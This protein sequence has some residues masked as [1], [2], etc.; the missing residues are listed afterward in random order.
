MDGPRGRRHS[1]DA[2]LGGY[3]RLVD[4]HLGELAGRLVV[5]DR[6]GAVCMHACMGGFVGAKGNE[7]EAAVSGRAWTAAKGGVK[8]RTGDGGVGEGR[9]RGREGG[10]HK[11]VEMSTSPPK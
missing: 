5:L 11:T 2:F 4:R 9:E 8:G 6:V 1:G 10:T 7:W 3:E